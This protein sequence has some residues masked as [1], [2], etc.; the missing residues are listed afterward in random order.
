MPE[1]DHAAVSRYWAGVRSSILG[2]YRMDDFGFPVGAGHFRFRAESRIVWRLLQGVNPNGT[3]LDLGCGVGYWAAAFAR[4]FS[5]VVAVEGSGALYQ[6][7]EARSAAYPNIRPV[8]GN[9]LSFEPDAHYC[10]IFLG[11]LLMYLDEEDVIAL[12]GRLVASLEPGGIILCRESTVR[13]GTETYAGDYPVVYRS[14]QNYRRIFRQCGLTVRHA[15]RNEPYVLMQM[16]CELIKKWKGLVPES[17]QML[18]IVGPL[19]YWVMRLGNPW[20]NRLP[21]ALEIPFPKLENHFFVL[22]TEAA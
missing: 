14:M 9:V 20:L 1:I 19:T 2:P 16:G 10:L 8:L 17:A 3:V 21:K 5:R 18:Q 22:E 4:C 11:G 12:L 6:A 13:G 15:E 7:L